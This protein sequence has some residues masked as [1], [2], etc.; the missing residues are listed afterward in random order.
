MKRKAIVV[1]GTEVEEL[2]TLLAEGW[3]VASIC[4]M[5][6]SVA[7]SGWTG[8]R[9]NRIEPHCLVILEKLGA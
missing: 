1:V 4:G 7:I 2:N 5:P 3:E 9:E 6:S 8:L